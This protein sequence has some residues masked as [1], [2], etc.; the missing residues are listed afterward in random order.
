MRIPSV[1]GWLPLAFALICCAFSSLSMADARVQV[2][3]IAADGSV[4]LFRDRF[5][6]SFPHG[7]RVAE[8]RT[9]ISNGFLQAVRKGFQLDGSCF[10][11]SAN[12]VDANGQRIAA[13]TLSP[14]RGLF[15]EA[16]IA[17]HQLLCSDS[18]CD[19]T[20]RARCNITEESDGKC[21]CHI[22]T[23]NVPPFYGDVIVSPS[24]NLCS[25][26][27]EPHWWDFSDWLV[28]MSTTP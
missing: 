21:R 13:G 15:F 8:L 5:L 27:L 10:Q 28:Q 6:D 14:G 1:R 23:L 22:K 4:N 18:G 2:G 16:V 9:E 25:S 26:I 12:I 24:T 19:D 17:G 7:A 3:V 11:E 20:P